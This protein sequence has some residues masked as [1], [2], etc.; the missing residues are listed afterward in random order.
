MAGWA[1]LL[2]GDVAQRPC[3]VLTIKVN[4]KVA[5]LEICKASIFVGDTHTS[6][7]SLFS[8]SRVHN[9]QAFLSLGFV[10]LRLFEFPEFSIALTSKFPNTNFLKS[11]TK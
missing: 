6:L 7:E 2:L 8:K 3:T 9:F 5:L 4:K 11:N 1:A 10:Q